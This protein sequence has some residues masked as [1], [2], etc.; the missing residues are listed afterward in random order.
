MFE[1]F[2]IYLPDFYKTLRVYS[3]FIKENNVRPEYE[4]IL[5]KCVTKFD[6]YLEKVKKEAAF[7]RG[8]NEI[9]FET[10]AETLTNLIDA[11]G[12]SEE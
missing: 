9:Q 4:N 12:G 7:E 5:G 6:L 2:E 1:L 3:N 11:E 10:T 8:S